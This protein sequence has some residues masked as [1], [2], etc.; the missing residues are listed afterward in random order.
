MAKDLASRIVENFATV[1]WLPDRGIVFT[2]DYPLQMI[3]MSNAHAIELDLGLLSSDTDL[4]YLKDSA[5]LETVRRSSRCCH[6]RYDS[7]QPGRTRAT[8]PDRS[9]MRPLDPEPDRIGDQFLFFP[10]FHLFF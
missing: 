4:S 5:R 7:L 1:S 3:S 2:R 10:V 6:F 8:H 9:R